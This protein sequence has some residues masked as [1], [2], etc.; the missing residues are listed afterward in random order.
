MSG[1]KDVTFGL[2][3]LSEIKKGVDIVADAVKSTLGPR[4]RNVIIE[5]GFGAP[6]ITKDGVSVA[7]EIDLPDAL[8]NM[9]ASLVKD[10]AARA[11]DEAGDGTTSATVLTQAIFN[12]GYKLVAAGAQP[13]EIKRGIDKITKFLVE[14]IKAIA[15]PVTSKQ[16]IA[17]VGSISANNEQEIGDLIADAMDQVGKDGVVTVDESPDNNTTLEIEEGFEFEKGWR[18]T[19]RHFLFQQKDGGETIVLQKPYIMCYGVM[20][21]GYSGLK[22]L[23]TAVMKSGRPLLIVAPQYT[24]IIT[25]IL[26]KNHMQGVPVYAVTSPGFGD[27][28]E[29]Y[30]EDLVYTTG[31]YVVGMG[32]LDFLKAS[33]KIDEFLGSADRVVIKKAS[34]TIIGGKGKSSDVKA[35]IDSLRKMAEATASPFDKEKIQERIGK[36]SG[37]IAVIRVGGNSEVEIKEKKDRVEDALCA[38]R[39]AVLGGIVPGGGV[40]LLMAKKAVMAAVKPAKGKKAAAEGRWGCTSKDQELGCELVLRA[41]ESPIRCIVSNAGGMPDVVVNAIMSGAEKGYNAH[42]D[43]YE[44]LVEAGVVDP[45]KVTLT[46]LTTA[47][48][49]AGTLLTT[50]CSITIHRERSTGGIFSDAQLIG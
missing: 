19:S 23:L 44:D 13:I 43:V 36:L 4:G 27:L 40:A 48:S 24:T 28:R 22:E 41:I 12:E 38:T 16:E 6:S 5:R 25:E 30:L 14:E 46:A 34:T 10:A 1:S 35:R 15:K 21:S 8:Q 42:T 26:V 11:G 3:G 39:A 45:A 20:F 31:G 9:G 50:N 49:I 37:G 32:G 33:E 29:A 17:Q 2:E 18:D 47:A 7:K